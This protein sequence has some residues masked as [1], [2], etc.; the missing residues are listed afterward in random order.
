MNACQ[1]ICK[2]VECNA[3]TQLSYNEMESFR[4]VEFE[5]LRTYKS[6]PQKWHKDNFDAKVNLGWWNQLCTLHV[7]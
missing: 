6:E 2:R 1:L 4:K 5:N 3:C 7:R